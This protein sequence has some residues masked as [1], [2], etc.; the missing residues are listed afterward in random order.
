MKSEIR[1]LIIGI[2]FLLVLAQD[3]FANV[4]IIHSRGLN[5]DYSVTFGAQPDPAIS[6]SLSSSDI[7]D[8]FGSYI[9]EVLGAHN[10]VLF[11][12]R[13][14]A[15]SGISEQ[16]DNSGLLSDVETEFGITAVNVQLGPDFS[17]GTINVK[18]SFGQL[19][20]SQI[21]YPTGAIV[22]IPSVQE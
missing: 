9:I 17:S 12:S 21:I 11:T 18:T 13:F 8:P 7:Q 6:P 4:N 14:N 16:W 5:Y 20:A 10:Q 2:V 1:A 15:I 22:N 19:I 3:V